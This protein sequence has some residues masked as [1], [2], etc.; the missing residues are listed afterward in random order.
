MTLAT[1]EQDKAAG[2]VARRR[3]RIKSG[4]IVTASLSI[5]GKASP[6]RATLRFKSG[7]T[8]QRPIGQIAAES[9]FEALKAG[10]RKLREEKIV[11]GFGWHWIDG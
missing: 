11:E 4:D 1:L 5:T 2:G 10:W 8:I 7:L 9:K 6:F 3:I